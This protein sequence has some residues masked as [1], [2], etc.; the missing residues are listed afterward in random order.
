MRSGRWKAIQV[1]ADVLDEDQKG[2]MVPVSGGNDKQGFP[3]KQSVLTLGRVLLLLKKRHSCYRT[4]REEAQVCLWM[5]CACQS[6]CSQLGYCLKGGK[7][8]G[9]GGYGYSWTEG[10][11]CALVVWTQKG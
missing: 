3:K 2:C 8:R 9:V 10:F 5:H 7:G 1:A 4:R 6:E 11:Y